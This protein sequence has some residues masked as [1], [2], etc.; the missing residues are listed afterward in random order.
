MT[1]TR[2]TPQ[3]LD[4]LEQKAKA[5]TPGP[6]QHEPDVMG[7][8]PDAGCAVVA[9]IDRDKRISSP[10]R[11]IVAWAVRLVSRTNAETSSNAA[12]IAANSPDVTL[13][14]I[15]ALRIEREARETA[16][17]E[18]DDWK[19]ACDKAWFEVDETALAEPTL[20]LPV[21]VKKL[22]LRAERAE[23]ERDA[24]AR[25][26]DRAWVAVR[27]GLDADAYR[28]G[29][30]D[31][32]HA[33]EHRVHELAQQVEA[34]RQELPSCDGCGHPAVDHEGHPLAVVDRGACEQFE[35]TPDRLTAELEAAQQDA[36]RLREALKA[37]DAAL[38]GM[39]SV[40]VGEFTADWGDHYGPE[41]EDFLAAR[42]KACA[43]LTAP[44]DV[45]VCD[46]CGRTGPLDTTMSRNVAGLST[47]AGGCVR[48]ADPTGGQ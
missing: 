33:I 35:S 15:D 11:G 5:A 9:V 7:K 20:S 8:P 41:C 45:G 2:L 26:L 47:C 24:L 40:L 16:E 31:L 18:R 6:W 4:E 10:T 38:A 23:A 30:W 36:A 48:P 25:A 28:A 39:N 21:G 3:A 42:Q 17:R 22:R 19:C 27:A 46:A 43:A 32:E 14:L 44:A 34:L 1:E 12:H 37:S 13:A 29:K